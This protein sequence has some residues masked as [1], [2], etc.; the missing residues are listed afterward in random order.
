MAG[1][2]LPIVT[3]VQALSY[4][5]ELGQK[6]QLAGNYLRE[7]TFSPDTLVPL[8]IWTVEIGVVLYFISL[9]LLVILEHRDKQGAA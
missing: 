3:V 5:K 6:S 7:A 4:A 8:A 2:V 9:L 1:L